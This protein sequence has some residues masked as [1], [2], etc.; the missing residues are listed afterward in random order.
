ME[1]V[2]LQKLL[3]EKDMDY[4]LKFDLYGEDI[5]YFLSTYPT[6][7]YSFFKNAGFIFFSFN[8][9]SAN[10]CFEIIANNDFEHLLNDL[11][12]EGVKCEYDYP[13]KY[14]DDKFDEDL[15]D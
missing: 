14:L 1:V 13:D 5:G 8:F 2:D 3:K 12:V 9:D 11:K 6:K 10:Y 15:E 4:K 7:F